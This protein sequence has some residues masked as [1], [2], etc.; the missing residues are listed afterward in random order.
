MKVSVIIR[1]KN[2]ERWIGH[3]IQSVLDHLTKPEIIV[4]DNNSTDQ[5]ID[6]VNTFKEDPLLKKKDNSNYTS[7][8]ILKIENYTPGRA[9]NLGASKAKN[10]IILILSSHCVLTKINLNQI[11]DDLKSYVAIFGKQIPVY[12][13]KKIVPRYIWSHFVSKRVTNMYS[14]MEGRPFLH[15][16][17]AIYKRDYLIKN[18]FDENLVSKEDRYWAIDA[19]SNKK[20]ILYDPNLEVLHHYTDNGNTWKGIA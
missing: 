3:A 14:S 20:N 6:I 16:A 1:T 13:G 9:L 4:V 17:I 5:T 15:N 7:I 18:K 19:K 10:N 11:N 12:N 2:E 8:K